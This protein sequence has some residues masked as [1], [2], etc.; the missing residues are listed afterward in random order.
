[1]GVRADVAAA[2]SAALVDDEDEPTAQVVGYTEAISPKPDAPVVVIG[3]KTVGPGL[4]PGRRTAQLEVLCSV[5]KQNPGT[6]DDDLEDLLGQV[7]DV[8]DDFD[9][10]LWTTAER[11]TYLDEAFPAFV[12]TVNI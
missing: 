12:I 8:L 1:M 5:A 4:V 11:A 3:L 7:L 9:W 10:A 6:A 2:L